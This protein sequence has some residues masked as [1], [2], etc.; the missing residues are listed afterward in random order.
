MGMFTNFLNYTNIIHRELDI[1]LYLIHH[2]FLKNHWIFKL[3][4]PNAQLQKISLSL[5]YSSAFS[6][7][8]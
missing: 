6:Y 4:L 8:Y 1:L 3:W 7:L 5:L 2:W